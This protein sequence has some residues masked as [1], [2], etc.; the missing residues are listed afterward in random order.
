MLP[1]NIIASHPIGDWIIAA[2]GLIMVIS[3]NL[4]LIEPIVNLILYQLKN[5]DNT[6]RVVIVYT[7]L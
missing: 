1:V 6:I 4:V 2:A 3:S 7:I 5:I